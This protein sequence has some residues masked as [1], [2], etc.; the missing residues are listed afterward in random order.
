MTPRL[1]W[2]NFFME[3]ADVVAKRSTCARRPE[4]VGCVL[5][6]DKH[7]IST[8]YA[9]SAHGLPHC[10]DV[11]C[12]IDPVTGGCVRT[13]HAEQNAIIHAR[14]D[15]RGA[16]AYTTLSP[17]W[18]CMKM[19]VQSGLTKILYKEEYRL[20]VEQQTGLAES[21]KVGFGQLLPE[22]VIAWKT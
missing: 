22:G 13:I 6:R 9:G 16:V 10:H 11:G 3:I 19:L 7:L 18:V 21:A 4:G 5:V 15:L 1:G 2:D 12:T 8:G 17:C 20:G 14:T